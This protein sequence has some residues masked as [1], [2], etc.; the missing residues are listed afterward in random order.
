MCLFLGSLMRL[1]ALKTT[2]RNQARGVTCVA[3]VVQLQVRGKSRDDQYIVFPEHYCSCKAFQFDVVGRSDAPFVSVQMFTLLTWHGDLYT[4]PLS[5]WRRGQ[6]ICH[7]FDRLCSAST[8]WRRASPMHW[9]G[10]AART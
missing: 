8:S 2:V 9:A 3:S 4:L 10:A 5:P 6:R 7:M 1:L